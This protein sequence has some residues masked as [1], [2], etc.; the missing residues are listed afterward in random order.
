MK[1]IIQ[2]PCFNEEKTLPLVIRDLPGRLPH[3]DEIE[4][5]VIDDGSAENTMR[6]NVEEK[7]HQYSWETMV[8]A[9]DLLLHQG[10]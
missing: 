9:I 4:Y 3:V 8:E 10:A 6:Q 7:K 1:L 5:L 2:I